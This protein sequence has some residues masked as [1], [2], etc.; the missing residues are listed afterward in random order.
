MGNPPISP[1]LHPCGR[2]LVPAELLGFCAVE[3]DK[4]P[5]R[6]KSETG[7]GNKGKNRTMESWTLKGFEQR[8]GIE[9]CRYTY[10]R[11]GVW[12]SRRGEKEGRR[13]L[14][15]MKMD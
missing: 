8:V 3:K 2:V 9:G 6:K 7:V 13:I 10:G 4:E 12:G 15:S 14:R 11:V 1:L 5:E